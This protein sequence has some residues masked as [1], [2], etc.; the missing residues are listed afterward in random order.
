[1]QGS[2][3][4]FTS[5]IY[6]RG[7]NDPRRAMSSNSAAAMEV[8]K[9]WCKAKDEEEEEA[10]D[11]RPVTVNAH[12]RDHLQEMWN[13]MKLQKKPPKSSYGEVFRETPELKEERESSD[14]IHHKKKD[15]LKDYFECVHRHK[16]FVR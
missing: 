16:Y 14:N 10:K 8:A 4:K 13:S 2:N 7:G 6:S 5:N 1:M 12:S 3:F 15:W 9:F 11:E